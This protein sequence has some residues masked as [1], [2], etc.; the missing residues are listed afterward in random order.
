MHTS[1]DKGTVWVKL[2]RTVLYRITPYHTIRCRLW[3]AAAAEEK[4]HTLNDK[5]TLLMK[6]YHSVAYCFTLKYAIHWVAGAA[7]EKTHTLNDKDT[8]WTKIR[9]QH[10]ATTFTSVGNFVSG[11]LLTT[12]LPALT[13]CFAVLY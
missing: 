3:V 1:N 11:P 2:Y 8:L 7:E 4:P 9:H 6:L 10:I 13:P 5:D 12:S